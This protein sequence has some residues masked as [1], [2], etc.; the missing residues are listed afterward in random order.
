MIRLNRN[1][2]SNSFRQH[3]FIVLLILTVVIV[4]AS[5]GVSARPLSVRID[6]WLEIRNLSGS[7]AAVQNGQVL[8]AQVGQ[9]IS[10]IGDGIRT[11]PAS[12]ARLAVDTQIGFVSVSENTD[13]RIIDIYTTQRGGKVTKLD[14]ER[15]QARLFV[16]PFT[17][18]E[19]SFEMRTPSGINGVRGTDFGVAI[20]PSG[21]SAVAVLEGGVSSEA[22]GAAV[23]VETGFQSLTNP[24]EPPS[25]PVPATDETDLDVERLERR[26]RTNEESMVMLQGH[27]SPYNLLIVEGE[28][29]DTS[30]EGDFDLLLPLP[31]NE[32]F[33]VKVVTPLGTKQVYELVVP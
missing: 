28:T 4:S 17:H 7:V 16:R 6:R 26:D 14:V 24:G 31:A 11:G 9:R 30:R 22:E 33:H 25:P 10:S 32:R 18:P 2:L 29:Q 20:Q 1:M 15:G 12:L 23:L 8:Q 5:L 13:L 21:R 3:R 27:L 19:S